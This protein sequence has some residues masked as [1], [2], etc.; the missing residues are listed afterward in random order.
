MP[1]F[2]ARFSALFLV[3]CLSLVGCRPAVQ[4][5]GD[6]VAAVKGLAEAIAKNDLVLYSRLA[7]PPALHQKMQARWKA[8]LAI[9][10]P[11]TP[12]QEQDYAKWMARF[13]TAN[14]EAKLYAD[15]DPKL[16]KLETELGS[17]WPLMQATA[18]IFLKG[19]IQANGT[20]TAS[21]KSHAQEIGSVLVGWIQP[22]LFTDRA[23]ARKTLAAMVA[24]ARELN[25]PTLRQSRA[26]EMIPALEKGGVAL[27]G[28]KQIGRIYGVDS[29][30]ALRAVQA[31][32]IDVQGDIA[33]LQVSYSLLGKTIG[34]EMQLIRRDQRWY[35]AD[36]VRSAEADLAQPLVPVAS[37]R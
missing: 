19:V 23:R 3:L 6:P 13:T 21:E 10:K 32:V 31:K 16:K 18:G 1:L 37:V 24:T 20:L 36:A 34:F 8:K 12:Q 33:T 30:T 2:L 7:V 14:A 22:S 4:A 9:A 25:L 27:K 5:P 26:L 28:V 15:L 35:S 29:D 11:P 17:Q